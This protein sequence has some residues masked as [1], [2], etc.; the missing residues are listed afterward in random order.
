MRRL[1]PNRRERERKNRPSM[2]SPVVRQNWSR[3]HSARP[4][5]CAGYADPWSPGSSKL[6]GYSVP[7]PECQRDAT[8][9]V[10]LD[11][12]AASRGFP[13]RRHGA[14]PPSRPGCDLRRGVRQQRQRVRPHLRP[15]RATLTLAEPV[16][17][18][19][20][21][22][23]QRRLNEP[24]TAVIQPRPRPSFRQGQSGTRTGVPFNPVDN[25]RGTDLVGAGSHTGHA[26]IGV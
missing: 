5:T 20:A 19:L 18:E 13:R 4:A 16:G 6:F 11:P 3:P 10:S 14:I 23:P 17:G 25:P 1:S 7:H 15:H 9:H 2:W 12:T 8:S 26:A 22:T 21:F 24:L